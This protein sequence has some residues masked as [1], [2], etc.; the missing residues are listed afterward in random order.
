MRIIGLVVT[1]SF[2]YKKYRISR[3]LHAF[4]LVFI[5]SIVAF[6][7][8]F[9]LVLLIHPITFVVGNEDV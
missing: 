5:M 4:C 2:M 7:I 6:Q 3:N 9:I 1:Y 8:N